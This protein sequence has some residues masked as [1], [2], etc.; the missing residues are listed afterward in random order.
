MRTNTAVTR[1]VTRPARHFDRGFRSA[2]RG[3][4]PAVALLAAC[5]GSLNTNPQGTAGSVGGAGDAGA[6][7]MECGTR[8]GAGN[9]VLSGQAGVGGTTGIGGA[10]SVGTAGIGGTGGGGATGIG[11]S[12]GSV[13]LPACAVNGPMFGVCF[14][15]D[16]EARPVTGD[17]QTSGAATIEAVGSGATPVSCSNVR[18]IGMSE[19]SHWWFQARAADN[20]LWT[21]GV[22]GLGGTPIV[23]PG[24]VVTLDLDW[25]VG[26]LGI[27]VTSRNGLLQVSDAAGTPLLWAGSTQFRGPGLPDAPTWISF[28]AGDYACGSVDMYCDRRERNVIATVN[29]SSMTLPPY[30]AASLGGYSLQVTYFA[31]FCADW[32]P[33]FEAAAAKVSPSTDP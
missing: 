12:G 25:D 24:D 15:N 4:L 6:T 27:G 5:S 30:G 7:G 31:H 21:I 3:S 33:P 19:P 22:R 17:A 9:C 23:R 11:G 18:Y 16:A 13:P 10:D 32:E 14:V 1:S 26:Y 29:G 28:A 8:S 2:L 20:R